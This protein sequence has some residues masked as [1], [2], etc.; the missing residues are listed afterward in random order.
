MWVS[1][2]YVVPCR[3]RPAHLCITSTH[4]CQPTQ[5]CV[6]T[7]RHDGDDCT[8]CMTT[9]PWR[10]VSAQAI[11][12]YFRFKRVPFTHA[13]LTHF[14]DIT[15]ET[16]TYY[17]PTLSG[18][19]YHLHRCRATAN[20]RTTKQEGKGLPTP[21]QTEAASC[22]PQT[23]HQAR[24]PRPEPGIATSCARG[25]GIPVQQQGRGGTGRD[26]PWQLQQGYDQKEMLQA[27][28]PMHDQIQNTP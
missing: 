4:A 3:R 17:P 15:G 24:T 27:T 20:G 21:T 9:R 26:K 19:G 10:T 23:K 28:P 18:K 2:R 11:L 13:S 12:F 14:T 16:S 25:G 6:N 22:T 1:R 7:W 5:V 8:A